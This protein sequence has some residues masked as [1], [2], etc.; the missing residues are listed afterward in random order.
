M[1]GCER[2]TFVYVRM[3]CDWKSLTTSLTYCIT[4]RIYLGI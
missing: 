3:E 1:G 4:S 2:S